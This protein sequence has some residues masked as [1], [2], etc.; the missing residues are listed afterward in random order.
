MALKII[1]NY[2]LLPEGVY[3]PKYPQTYIYAFAYNSQT[4]VLNHNYQTRELTLNCIDSS[5]SLTIDTSIRMCCDYSINAIVYSDNIIWLGHSDTNEYDS[6][7][8]VSSRFYIVDMQTKISHKYHTTAFNTKLIEPVGRNFWTYTMS[9]Q[10]SVPIFTW[11][12]LTRLGDQISPVLIGEP[13]TEYFPIDK[14]GASVV[15]VKDQTLEFLDSKLTTL[16]VSDVF[17]FFPAYERL[18]HPDNSIE[19]TPDYLVAINDNCLLYYEWYDVI[20]QKWGDI[21]GCEA[22]YCFDFTTEQIIPF[23]NK[24]LEYFVTHVFPFRDFDGVIKLRSSEYYP[25]GSWKTIYYPKALPVSAKTAL[26]K[27]KAEEE[28]CKL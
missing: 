14:Y 17:S 11:D 1:Y 4:W 24:T 26:G 22:K 18:T 20:D 28:L 2:N 5:E 8:A 16:F 6:S 25:A 10:S 9:K 23:V 27:R 15:A 7:G 19:E 12:T 13:E 3:H 21:D